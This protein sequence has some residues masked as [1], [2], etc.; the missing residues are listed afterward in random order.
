MAFS[1]TG[2]AADDKWIIETVDRGEV[3][4]YACHIS[5]SDGKIHIAYFDDFKGDLKHAT[6]G[7]DGWNIERVDEDGTVGQ[8]LSMTRD[9]L[10]Q[11]Y[12]GYRD[13]GKNRLKLAIFD[14]AA[15]KFEIVDTDPFASF[16]TSMC[17]DAQGKIC[18]S[19]FNYSTGCLKLATKEEDRWKIE[20][21]DC[22]QHKSGAVGGFSSLKL[23]SKNRIHISYTDSIHGF[24]KYAVKEN[25]AWNIEIADDSEFVGHYTS[26]AL[27]KDGAPY[28]SYTVDKSPNKPDLWFAKKVEGKW[29]NELVDTA[30]IAGNYNSIVIDRHRNV[31][32]SY[33]AMSKLKLAKS[34]Q[35]SW[36]SEIIDPKGTVTYTTL[37]FD[38]DGAP[39]I[40]YCDARSALKYAHKGRR[41]I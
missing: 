41:T 14:G 24:L 17:V 30:N 39:H 18:I 5:G 12:I 10:G 15:W 27:D 23:D 38:S 3:G 11:I 25:G 32:I 26:L 20:V 22:G 35:G 36:S 28:I 31:F 19:Y 6:R 9:S 33:S 34:I 13:Q 29:I 40:T 1:T 2:V 4:E 16:D 37:S 21:V 8:Y 7:P